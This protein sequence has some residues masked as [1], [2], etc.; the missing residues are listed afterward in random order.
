MQALLN[1]DLR[2]TID[3][4]TGGV[5]WFTQSCLEDLH[6]AEGQVVNLINSK[7]SYKNFVDVN[8]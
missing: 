5:K 3:V 4:S 1:I 2:F 7:T 6:A 8:I